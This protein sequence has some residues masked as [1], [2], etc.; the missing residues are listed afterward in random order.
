[1]VSL[2]LTLLICC[3]FTVVAGV[4]Y[5]LFKELETEI[6]FAS[7]IIGGAVLG[8][9]TYLSVFLS[10]GSLTVSGLVWVVLFV[11]GVLGWKAFF[12]SEQRQ[13]NK[14]IIEKTDLIHIV[15]LILVV[16]L[17]FSQHVVPPD[18]D[19][20]YT[21]TTA[22]YLLVGDLYP[23]L[24]LFSFSENANLH[25]V[26]LPDT[27]ALNLATA[28]QLAQNK[29]TQFAIAFACAWSSITLIALLPIAQRLL[30]QEHRN[31]QTLLLV[32]ACGLS[33]P[34][35][36][37]YGDGSYTRTPG[38]AVF[39]ALPI[40][41][42]VLEKKKVVPFS[43]LS[44]I[45]LASLF[46]VHQR[47]ALVAS[48][49]TCI[50][51]LAY[52]VIH[53]KLA[54]AVTLRAAAI[55]GVSTILLTL[56]LA[57]NF[58]NFASQ[59]TGT[60]IGNA[61]VNRT[62]VEILSNYTFRFHSA[63]S[64]LL[65]A[66]G[67]LLAIRKL[68]CDVLLL[69]AFVQIITFIY[70]TIPPLIG[71]ITPFL[72]PL[73]YARVV[74][75]SPIVFGKFIF[76]AS[77]IIILARWMSEKSK[78][79]SQR[80]KSI[81]AI[82]GWLT[83]FML[84]FPIFKIIELYFTSPLFR[85]SG[86]EFTAGFLTDWAP[87]LISIPLII[88]LSYNLLIYKNRN[89]AKISFGALFFFMTSVYFV[90][91]VRKGVINNPLSHDHLFDISDWFVNNTSASETLIFKGCNVDPFGTNIAENRPTSKKNTVRYEWPLDWLPALAQRK[92]LCNRIHLV[93]AFAGV[94]GA[95][96]RPPKGFYS[97]HRV[98]YGTANK[99]D[100]KQMSKLGLTHIIDSP[101]TRWIRGG[102]PLPQTIFQRVY[103][104]GKNGYE[105][106]TLN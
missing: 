46:Y 58:I 14:K 78:L 70:F 99:N 43:L 98:L 26:L 20:Q 71:N 103:S 79:A 28:S 17:P 3:Y 57:H 89:S 52:I 48:F 30:C 41:W 11:F 53:P 25:Q 64:W 88:F 15:T 47:Y 38:I 51:F 18:V 93:G 73:A 85:I 95:G 102:E 72:V 77:F 45:L 66:M 56:P 23:N 8:I 42:T 68:R 94:F 35:L 100:I 21:T 92:T 19:A 6:L 24:E 63:I 75:L 33:A 91:D 44:A 37:N 81:I 39:V 104:Q 10:G 80:T 22:A 62:T 49:F 74:A 60:L 65:V 101:T 16:T 61:E 2:F 50:M 97:A 82:L 86:L 83:V 54:T 90:Y 59:G 36:W 7:P 55:M 76:V 96:F 1:M 12:E 31:Y 106:Y 27:F 5:F 105:I 32:L 69:A 29:L 67:L 87:A 84:I 34:F 13:C 4:L 9:F 40:F